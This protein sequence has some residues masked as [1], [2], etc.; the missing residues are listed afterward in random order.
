MVRRM[1][2]TY[3]RA[4]ELAT[5][6]IDLDALVTDRFDLEAAADAFESAATRTGDKT[7][8]VVSRS[9]G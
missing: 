5:S 7:V 3:D 9:A 6:G 8:V 1:H 4:I 2:E